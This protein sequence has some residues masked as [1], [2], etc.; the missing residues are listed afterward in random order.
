LGPDL[1]PGNIIVLSDFDGTITEEDVMVGLLDNFCDQDWYEF[2]RKWERKEVTLRE[3]LRVMYGMIKATKEDVDGFVDT[4][5]VVRKGFS[6]FVHWCQGNGIEFR[7][8][9]EGMDYVI[10]RT[11]GNVGVEAPVTTNHL[12]FDGPGI[13]VTF[14]ETPPLCDHEDKDICGTCK[15]THV[16]RAGT[17]GKVV[18][19][20]G[21]GS[22]DAR[23]AREADIV[24]A[25]RLLAERLA[26]TGT[27]FHPFSDFHEIR[28][29]LEA[30]MN[31]RRD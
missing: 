8:V 22:T 10:H 1:R 9:S 30:L 31:E 5:V 4:K 23:P 18:V 6:D 3:A 28:A 2:V 16:R 19:Y 29:P 13:K 7:V 21:D 26:A 20:I 11:L 12:V 15:V 27:D 17:G 25:R 24:F 14:P